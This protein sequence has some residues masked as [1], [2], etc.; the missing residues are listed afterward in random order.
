MSE[1]RCALFGK[2][3]LDKGMVDGGWSGWALL[4]LVYKVM[5]DVSWSRRAL[6]ELAVG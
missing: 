4:E 6:P 3:F 5:A 1:G 2:E